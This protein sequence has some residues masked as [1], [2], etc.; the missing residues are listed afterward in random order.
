MMGEIESNILKSDTK[1][2]YSCEPYDKNQQHIDWILNEIYCTVMRITKI[3]YVHVTMI[4]KILDR[5]EMNLILFK[6]V[7]FQIFKMQ[8]SVP[9][10][11][12]NWKTLNW[13]QKNVK[14]AHGSVN[15][16]IVSQSGPPLRRLSICVLVRVTVY[17]FLK[18][19]PPKILNVRYLDLHWK[20]NEFWFQNYNRDMS[21]FLIKTDG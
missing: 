14:W 20:C 12:I 18:N 7:L 3:S 4:T 13:R 19:I 2:N 6:A 8:A 9:Q 11:E 16:Y 17:L 15:Y 10:A 1:I 5:A 21:S